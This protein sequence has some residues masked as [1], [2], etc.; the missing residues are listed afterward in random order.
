M[1][2]PHWGDTQ[3]TSAQAYG[4]QVAKPKIAP[5]GLPVR[6]VRV[7]GFL[8]GVLLHGTDAHLLAQQG[9]MVR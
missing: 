8:M 4:N 6:S 7:K 1:V 5:P 3:L 2:A 9:E